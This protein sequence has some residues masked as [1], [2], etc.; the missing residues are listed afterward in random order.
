MRVLPTLRSVNLLLLISLLLVITIGSA[1]QAWSPIWG[2]VI[3]EVF[4]ILLPAVIFLRILHYPV[5]ATTQ[6]RWPGPGLAGLS[7]LV[8][9]C[10]ALVA[11][12]WGTL[13]SSLFGYTFALPPEFYPASSIQAIGLFAALAF[14]APVCEEFLFRGVIQ[15]GY[16]RRGPWTAIIIVGF[17]FALYH[18]SFQRLL[19][20]IPVAF[21]LGFV[22]WRSAA[23]PSSMLVHS[24][25]NAFSGTLLL[26]AVYRPELNL[27]WIGS[28]PVT[29]AGL[30]AGLGGMWLFNRIA[31]AEDLP[32]KYSGSSPASEVAASGSIPIAGKPAV[33]PAETS[34]WLGRTWPLALV[35]LLFL[36]LAGLEFVAGRF[37]QLLAFGPLNLLPQPWNSPQ[38]WRY[39]L[40][41]V[42]DVP[43]GSARCTLALETSAYVLEC[44]I[45]QQAFEAQ[46][47][48]SNYK[49][50]AYDLNQTTRWDRNSLV[51]LSL[52]GTQVGASIDL[53]WQVQQTETGP[54]LHTQQD[55]QSLE[56]LPLPVNPF[57]EAEWPWRMQAL[58]FNL[59]YSRMVELAYPLHWDQG[60]GTIKPLVETEY[61]VVRTAE[62]IWTPAG[63]FIAW[64]V[65]VG[66]KKAWYD[67]KAPHTLLRYDDG[68]VTYLL[69]EQ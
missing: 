9:V 29:I 45:E 51:L 17:Y 33:V 30:V 58:P 6:L 62:P 10:F 42:L 34:S 47:G 40:Q 39:E 67:S 4:L 46:S 8:G 35:M 41:N 43:V 18:L 53:A 5:R 57:F 49:S 55:G 19:D 27:D 52:E 50:G 44:L 20:I 68:I 65:T 25:Y 56:D 38:E 13:I 31:G 63:R 69:L 11:I 60:S 2:T 32:E 22:A 28:F 15:R 12:G 16:E 1:V 37:P 26:L 61:L 21:V 48:S 66:D 24:S 54:V 23:L 59:G 36:A 3:T 14:F 7:L 64:A